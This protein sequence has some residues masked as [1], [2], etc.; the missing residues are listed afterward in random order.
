MDF[1]AINQ[2]LLTEANNLAA[3]IKSIEDKIAEFKQEKQKLNKELYISI[4]KLRMIAELEPN[5]KQEQEK[6]GQPKEPKGE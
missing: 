5:I 2:N 3:G 1:K 6:Q 4:G